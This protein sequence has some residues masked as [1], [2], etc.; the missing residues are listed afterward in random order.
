MAVKGHDSKKDVLSAD[1]GHKEVKLSH[2]AIE[3][4]GLIM[5]EEVYQ[6]LGAD[7]CDIPHLQEGKIAQEEVHGLVQLPIA[8][9][10]QDNESILQQGQQVGCQEHEE[11][12]HL[13]GR[14]CW[15]SQKNEMYGRC[16]VIYFQNLADHTWLGAQTKSVFPVS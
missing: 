14:P 8:A 10:G 4:D 13:E 16:T 1:K 6:H 2:A 5:A 15:K 3:G 7:D 9:N 11:E 12:Q